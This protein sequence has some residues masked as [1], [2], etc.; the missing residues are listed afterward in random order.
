MGICVECSSDGLKLASF[1][2]YS[3]GKVEGGRCVVGKG[4]LDG[5]ID[6]VCDGPGVG[7]ND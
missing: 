6:G 4:I 5:F 1:V 2:R 3:E 7:L